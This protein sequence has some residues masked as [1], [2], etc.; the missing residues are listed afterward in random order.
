MEVLEALCSSFGGCLCDPLR[1]PGL[2]MPLMKFSTGF[3]WCTAAALTKETHR[4]RCIYIR[5]TRNVWARQWWGIHAMG[6]VPVKNLSG[7]VAR[8]RDGKRE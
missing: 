5:G 4:E 2:G 7:L 1:A 3:S 6:V 8:E